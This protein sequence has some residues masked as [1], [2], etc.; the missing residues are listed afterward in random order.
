MARMTLKIWAS[1]FDCT[2]VSTID[3]SGRA[4]M[5]REVRWADT[6]KTT[7]Y[8]ECDDVLDER[9]L[10]L[11]R[12]RHARICRF[13]NCD[14]KIVE[15][16]EFIWYICD[17]A[18]C[19]SPKKYGYKITL[20]DY[21]KALQE[22][23]IGK[24]ID[25]SKPSILDESVL[26]QMTYDWS[27]WCQ[28]PIPNDPNSFWQII[29]T[30]IRNWTA[31]TSITRVSD[32]P[33]DE[34]PPNIQRVDFCNPETWTAFVRL[35]D[36][37][38][39]LAVVEY[40]S[41]VTCLP[42]RILTV[43]EMISVLWNSLSWCVNLLWAF[44]ITWYQNVVAQQK[45]Y[46]CKTTVYQFI[47]DLADQVDAVRYPDVSCPEDGWFISLKYNFSNC[48]WEDKTQDTTSQLTFD[49]KHPSRNTFDWFC[50][51]QKWW[52][53]SCLIWVSKVD[54][55]VGVS[56]DWD[57]ILD[58][59]EVRVLV[60]KEWPLWITQCYEVENWGNILFDPATY[61]AKLLEMTQ[62]ELDRICET[63][64]RY[65]LKI[66]KNRIWANVWDQLVLNIVNSK[67]KIDTPPWGL[68]T[69]VLR[70]KT[71][72]VNCIWIEE[73]T[74]WSPQL[75]FVWREQIKEV[76]RNL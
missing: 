9:F 64:T 36:L 24:T 72:F 15:K 7:V 22:F 76:L 47:Q 62:I 6:F 5:L 45:S 49:W 48:L 56:D 26:D 55:Q 4:E 34:S 70:K 27:L 68:T 29:F 8:C 57:P 66:W 17:V 30:P 41:N 33:C 54:F 28:N 2:V 18:P 10:A 32:I 3:I 71:T 1:L 23:H 61:Q 65:D 42:N 14:W 38:T 73:I 16:T 37:S 60:K 67:E 58:T 53:I 46:W 75:K 50:N 51:P 69:T 43:G 21:R 20:G 35:V 25:N 52:W 11:I 74:V 40:N 19:T 13:E 39:W 31:E 59:R 12:T 44:C 63:Q